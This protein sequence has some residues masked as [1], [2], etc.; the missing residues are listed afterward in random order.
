[1]AVVYL[2][3]SGDG[4]DGDEWDVRAIFSTRGKAKKFADDNSDDW[5]VE[6]WDVE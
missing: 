2:V 6:E 4:S 5:N 3:A 1:M